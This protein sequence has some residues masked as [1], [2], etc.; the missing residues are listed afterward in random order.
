[1]SSSD[2]SVSLDGLP[3]GDY[4]IEAWHEQLGT[5][6]SNVTVTTGGTAEI[7]FEFTEA[8]AGSPVPMGKPIDVLHPDGH[9]VVDH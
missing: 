5:M 1:M 7:S 2:G 3:P 9:Q 6:T 8:M 4:V